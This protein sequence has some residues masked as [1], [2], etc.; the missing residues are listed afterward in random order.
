[1]AN[2]L[3]GKVLMDHYQGIQDSKLWLYN[4]YGSPEEMPVDVFFRDESEMPELE[5][6]A[7]DLCR[8]RILDI[9]AGVGSHALV[10][11]NRGKE[12]TALEISATA[13][14]IMQSRGVKS[15][16]NEDVRKF[17]GE[18][19]DTLLLLMNGIGLTG[20][21]QGLRDF[22]KRSSKLLSPGG[23]LI[24]DSSDIAYLYEDLPMPADSYYGE[25]SYRYEYKSEFSEWFDWLYVDANSISTIAAEEGWRMELLM[26]DEM[27]QFLVRLTPFI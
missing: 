17:E 3:F 10:L 4:N 8:G 13:C 6:L 9:G 18:K 15:V 20:S 11:Q 21:L 2:D 25:I 26:E 7:L 14:K 12:V 1:M 27:D 24:F 23:Q 5:L 22:L 19:F 16:I